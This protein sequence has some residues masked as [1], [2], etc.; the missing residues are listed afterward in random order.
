MNIKFN[1]TWDPIKLTAVLKFFLSS[2]MIG[3]LYCLRYIKSCMKS[4]NEIEV[5]TDT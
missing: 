5:K 3:W 4:W 1:V 2:V